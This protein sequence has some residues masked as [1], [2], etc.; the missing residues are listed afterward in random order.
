SYKLITRLRTATTPTR[1]AMTFDRKYL[2]IG[3]DNAQVAFVYDLD[4]FDQQIPIYFP[5]G[6]YPRMLAASGNKLLA[7]GR[8]GTELSLT[9]GQSAV[10]GPPAAA[11][12]TA[13]DV[14]D[15]PARRASVLPTLGIYPNQ[16][17][18]STVLAAAPNG[19]LVMGAMPD[20]TVFLYN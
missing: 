8:A 19:N 16:V 3:H 12:K 10:I 15:F 11:L 2:L 18:G 20:G 7:V 1:L 6:H 4:T 14:V 5:F 13:I 17:S 9:G